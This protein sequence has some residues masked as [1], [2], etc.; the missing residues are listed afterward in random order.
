MYSE[1]KAKPKKPSTLKNMNLNVFPFAFQ[2]VP[3]ALA[4]LFVGM[5]VPC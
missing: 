5:S 4:E 1:G 3:N 2:M